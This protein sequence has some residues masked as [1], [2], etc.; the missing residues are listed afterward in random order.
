MIVV[1]ATFGQH[2]SSIQAYMVPFDPKIIGTIHSHPNE[3]GSPS[4]EDLNAFS[5]LGPVHIILAYPFGFFSANCYSAKGK[6]VRLK[7][8]E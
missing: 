8:I 5:K 7:I 1:P 6:I 3:S 2:H 4:K